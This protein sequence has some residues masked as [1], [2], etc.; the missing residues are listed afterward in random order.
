MLG[1]K[2]SGFRLAFKPCVAAPIGRGLLRNKRIYA[3]PQENTPLGTE[4]SKATGSSA[5]PTTA[6]P[7]T[8][9]TPPSTPPL[10]VKG[11]GTAIITGV[12]SIVFG[13]AYLVLVQLLD[14]G[15]MLPPPPE[16]YIP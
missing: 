9:A 12:I 7:S 15:E 13:I 6:D 11:Q 5:A 8:N 10:L 16:A 3:E 2:A 1:I 14:R 4:Q